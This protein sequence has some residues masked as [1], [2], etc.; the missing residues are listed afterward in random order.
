MADE[1]SKLKDKAS[2]VHIIDLLEGKSELVFEPGYFAIREG[3][4][5][6]FVNDLWN[7]IKKLAH[8]LGVR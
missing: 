1:K 4:D 8:K 6:G 3:F 2:S 5:F 7:G